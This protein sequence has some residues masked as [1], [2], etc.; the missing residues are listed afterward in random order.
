MTR[1]VSSAYVVVFGQKAEAA[2]HAT[3]RLLTGCEFK[4]DH[5]FA[6]IIVT[7]GYFKEVAATVSCLHLE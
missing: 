6:T 4:I 1:K 5:A 3:V 7:V 2:N